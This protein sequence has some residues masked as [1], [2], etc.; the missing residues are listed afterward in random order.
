MSEE[1]QEELIQII[2]RQTDYDYEKSKL[3]LIEFKLDYM[4]VIKDF[5]GIKKKETVCATSNQQRY[6]MIRE[7]MDRQIKNYESKNQNSHS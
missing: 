1:N 5:M 7:S 2:M 6:K 3:K 4:E